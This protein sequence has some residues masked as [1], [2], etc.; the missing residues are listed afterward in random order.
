MDKQKLCSKLVLVFLFLIISNGLFCSEKSHEEDSHYKPR[1]LK[2][3][4]RLFH[5]LIDKGDNTIN[6]ASCHNTAYIDEF[7]WNPS[8][9]EIAVKN[10][11]QTFDE[12]KN[13]LLNP[14]GIKMSEV[15]ANFD[16]TDEELGFLKNYLDHM[17][18]IGEKPQ[19]KVINDL[20]L[21]LGS[22]GLI[23]ILLVDLIFTKKIKY[24]IVHVILIL[25]AIGYQM[26]EIVTEAKAIG[27]SE[28]YEPDQ[29]IKFSHKIHAGENNIDC[30]YCHHIAEDSKSAGIPSNSVCMNC[31][32]VI[33]EG[34]NSGAFEIN[35]IWKAEETG[36][37]V[38]W[39]RIH[40]LPDHAYFNHS[41]HV[42]VAKLDCQECHGPVEEMDRVYQHSDLSMGWCINCHRDTEV[43]FEANQFYKKYDKLL[44]ELH[45][46][47]IDRV[48]AEKIGGTDCSKCH[49]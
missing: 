25:A 27:R 40:L 31:H 7:N 32:F 39:I 16:F 12:F 18:E 19:K 43:Q 42:N 14:T 15:H 29:P 45:E 21:F 9:F 37:P 3:G 38:E 17:A 44:Q 47:K 35:K 30:Q 41:Q 20:L 28:N 26:D 6:C 22:I 34:S 10:N 48:T 4:E 46:G 13:A 23:L 24:R 33:R 1:E 36:M 5:G 49:Y 11:H 8:A 2:L